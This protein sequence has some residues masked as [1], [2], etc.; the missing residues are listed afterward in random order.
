MG[1][2]MS[3]TSKD[4]QHTLRNAP[5]SLLYGYVMALQ[6]DP[7]YVNYW[8]NYYNKTGDYSVGIGVTLHYEMERNREAWVNS[9][10]KYINDNPHLITGFIPLVTTLPKDA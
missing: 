7:S 10:G 1:E 6:R 3:H 8:K 4:W 9:I 5:T 2:I